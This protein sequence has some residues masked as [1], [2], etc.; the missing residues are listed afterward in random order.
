MMGLGARHFHECPKEPML[1][2]YLVVGGAASLVLQLLPF[3]YCHTT[4]GKPNIVCRICNFVLYLF[5]FVWLIIGS[6][7]VYRAY[8]PN[9]ESSQSPEYCER[10]LY[11]VTFLFTTGIYINILIGIIGRCVYILLCGK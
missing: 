5:C 9:F 11:M 7:F 1:T 6:V 8:L 10:T 2:I 4:S 3:L